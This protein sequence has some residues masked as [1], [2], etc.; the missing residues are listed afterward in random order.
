MRKECV[1]EEEIRAAIRADGYP[2]LEKVHA[3]VLET[4][5]TFSVVRM[6]DPG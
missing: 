2:A 6:S 5:G 4:D 1:T 3:V